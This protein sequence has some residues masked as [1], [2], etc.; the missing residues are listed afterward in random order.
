[1]DQ[2]V[3]TYLT[4]KDNLEAVPRETLLERVKEG[5]V[6]VLDVRPAEEYDAGHVPGAV[7]VPLTELELYLE[8][9]PKKQEVVAYCRGPHCVL[10]LPGSGSGVTRPNGWKTAFP[11]G[12]PRATR[13][14]RRRNKRRVLYSRHL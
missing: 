5:L 3:D 12:N 13:L 11:N 10:A 9:L 1:V 6:T 14:K 7:N 4:V 8:N 2:L